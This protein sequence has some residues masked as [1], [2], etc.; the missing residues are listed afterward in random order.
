MRKLASP[1]MKQL[2]KLSIRYLARISQDL[3]RRYAP[4]SGPP[5]LPAPVQG[6]LALAPA[7]MNM[8]PASEALTEL[9]RIERDV[10]GLP[11]SR[12]IF[13]LDGAALPCWRES[14]LSLYDDW[15]SAPNYYPLYYAMFQKL[16]RTDR[17][18]RMLEIGVR[19]G[20][21]GATFARAARGACLYVGVDPNLYVSNGLQLA[22]QTF[23]LLR[24]RLPAAE[25]LLLEG[26]SW[27]A[28]IQ[29][30]L[31]YSG[32]FDI[33]HIDGDHTVPGKLID[34]DLARRLVDPGGVIL[35]DDYEHHSIVAD[36]IA[37]A[38]R[39]GWFRE[40]AYVPTKRGLAA[41]R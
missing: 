25:F 3:E 6:A 41:L 40:F 22:S 17:P 5:A 16:S 13:S 30:S 20:Y 29:R 21:M 27:D 23:K 12:D 38:W 24:A 1:R 26:Y 7:T 10:L 4:R 8:P 11:S 2:G 9:L 19:T 15:L 14:D 28:D 36:A 35:V 18:T 37:R 39:L 32:P 33:I 34:L 31:L